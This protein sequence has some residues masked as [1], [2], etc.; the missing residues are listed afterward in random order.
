MADEQYPDGAGN[1]ARPAGL[2]GSGIV[3]VQLPNDRRISI[4]TA[5]VRPGGVHECVRIRTITPLGE[6]AVE[7]D[8]P[9]AIWVGEII[10]RK[11]KRLSA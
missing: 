6:S 10:T 4:T 11:A 1:P 5:A 3:I 8:R 7:L 9:T 2:I